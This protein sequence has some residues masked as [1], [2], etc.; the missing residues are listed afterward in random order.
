MKLATPLS[1]WV[2]VAPR[3]K[4]LTANTPEDRL[5]ELV[6]DW[7]DLGRF[8]D[9]L[10]SAI[11]L[12]LTVQTD[13]AASQQGLAGCEILWTLSCGGGGVVTGFQEK[14]LD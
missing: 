9:L 3:V 1:K 5:T 14:G 4:G 11:L 8:W 7:V 6:L 10:A 12:R 13:F 2:S